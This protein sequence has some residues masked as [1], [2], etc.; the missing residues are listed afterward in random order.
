M[1]KIVFALALLSIAFAAGCYTPMMNFREMQYWPFMS[2]F[3]G[4]FA[5]LAWI[6]GLAIYFLP[7]IIA[8][9]RKKDNLLLIVLLNIFLGWTFVG[10][11]VA[12]VLAVI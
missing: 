12:L 6:I 5:F 10:W 7:T 8:A 3:W 9:A 2:L 4:P 11:I 1:K